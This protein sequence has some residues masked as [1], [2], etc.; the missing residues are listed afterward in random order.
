MYKIEDDNPLNDN[1]FNSDYYRDLIN[2]SENK[3][4]T[5][6]DD[7]ITQVH[8]DSQYADYKVINAEPI[9]SK[10]D[11]PFADEESD[12]MKI[13]NHG[14]KKG[15]GDQVE[16]L[17]AAP[18]HENTDVVATFKQ[19]FTDLNTTY[20]L[21]I[22]FDFNSFTKTL[23]YII[24]P[25]NMSAM[26]VYLSESYSRVRATLY[27][28][29]LNAI[30]Q[31]SQQI[32]DPRFLTSSSMSYQDKLILMRELFQYIDSLD[33]IYERIKV[34]DGD[35]KLKKLASEKSEVD[36]YNTPEVQEFMEAL[37]KNVREGKDTK[38]NKDNKDNK[39]VRTDAE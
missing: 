20:G 18:K 25:T 24:S 34:S 3:S 26:E 6:I 2:K 23:S 15:F 35:L 12:S 38:D 4:E 10:E 28:M 16:K 21:D 7:T 27:M 19:L 17:L 36:N 11:D 9:P 30:A 33:N 1:G 29:Y 31:L 8:D 32:L 39:G 37:L 22:K 5:Y 13:F 14:S